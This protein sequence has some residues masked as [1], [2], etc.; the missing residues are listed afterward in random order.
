MILV[1]VGNLDVHETF[2]LPKIIEYDPESQLWS[3]IRL[4][5]N[6][7]IWQRF[8]LYRT[9]TL[10]LGTHLSNTISSLASSI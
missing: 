10:F 3:S 4:P 8:L 9:T 6:L 2:L 5:S 1:K 7:A